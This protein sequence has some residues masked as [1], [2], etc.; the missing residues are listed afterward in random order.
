MCMEEKYSFSDTAIKEEYQMLREEIMHHKKRQNSFTT[1]S[2]TVVVA[3][4]GVAIER[5]SPWIALI[6]SLII[7]PTSFRVFESRLSISRI[8]SYLQTFIEPKLAYNWETNL[9]KYRKSKNNRYKDSAL[10]IISKCDF[11]F[12]TIG[13]KALFW[14][15]AYTEKLNLKT[16]AINTACAIQIV[17]LLA[18]FVITYFYYDYEKLKDA[19]GKVW[20]E[21]NGENKGGSDSDEANEQLDALKIP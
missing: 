6:A 5:G 21:I 20:N 12:L 18:V 17:A 2:Y 11:V 3:L 15:I 7:L 10:Y 9:S 16:W 4:W 14:L 13:S 1:F 8:S 19:N